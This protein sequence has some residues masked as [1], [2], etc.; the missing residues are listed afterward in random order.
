MRNN[1]WGVSEF[2][3]EQTTQLLCL[4]ATLVQMASDRTV[5]KEW[6]KDLL[7][8]MGRDHRLTRSHQRWSHYHTST[9]PKRWVTASRSQVYHFHPTTSNT[10]WGERRVSRSTTV[11]KRSGKFSIRRQRMLSRST[12][13]KQEA[14][15]TTS[16]ESGIIWA[17]N[18]D[19]ARFRPITMT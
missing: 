15:E 3:Q 4:R 11:P 13:C 8:H 19:K 5:T 6:D 1:T 7:T 18:Q 17:T 16:R 9:S 10:S 2:S 12:D 14:T